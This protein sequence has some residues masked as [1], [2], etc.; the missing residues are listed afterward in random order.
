MQRWSAVLQAKL[1]PR[2]GGGFST[3]SARLAANALQL[4]LTP[5]ALKTWLALR[6]NSVHYMQHR[7]Y[8]RRRPQVIFRMAPPS[9]CLPVICFMPA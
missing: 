7:K 3:I 5:Q 6:A 1:Q 9:R 8:R 4:C 2:E